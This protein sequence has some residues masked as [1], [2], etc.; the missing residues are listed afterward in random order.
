MVVDG[1]KGELPAC[2]VHRVAPVSR[3]AVA[4]PHDVP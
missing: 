3:E 1:Y 2:A 4:G